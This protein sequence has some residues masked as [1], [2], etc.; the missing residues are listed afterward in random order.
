[1]R[2]P[3]WAYR[4]PDPLV[5]SQPYLTNLGF[6]VTWDNP[7]ITVERGGTVV[8]QHE[9]QPATTY[10]IVARVW[11]G[12]TSGPAVD[13]PV[14]ASYFD[15]GIG[16]VAVPIGATTVD[17]PVKGAPGCPAFARLPWTTPAAP[18]HY[19]VQ[20]VLDWPD[21]AEPANNLGQ[22]NT[23]VKALNSPRAGFT[24]PLRNDAAHHRDL[25]LAVDEYVVPALPRC[26]ERPNPDEVRRR[27][28][29]PADHPVP[30]GWSVAIDPRGASLR[31]GETVDVS[32]EVLAPDG[33]RGR[34]TFN[35]NAWHGAVCV[36][37]VS[38]TVEGTA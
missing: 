2:I 32:V 11:N 31:P 27:H 23:D 9:L 17:L 14:R 38:L 19:C 1:M 20:V 33:F 13:L 25:T 24:F 8:D 28:G 34:K 22:S 16:T 12:S 26:D 10:D 3:S 6:A 29:S 18:G 37:G 7:D 5:Y 21:D 35:V 36:G 4:Q 30:E 15:M